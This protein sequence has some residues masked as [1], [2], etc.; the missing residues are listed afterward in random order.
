MIAMVFRIIFS[1]FLLLV[2][3]SAALSAESPKAVFPGT[4]FAFGKV[5]KGAAIEHEF[6]LRNEGGAPLR[7][8]GIR[9]TAPLQLG[10][11]PAQIEPNTEIK[12]R[13][14]LDTSILSGPFEDRS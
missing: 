13:V 9:A 11:M 7:I 10:R 5:M 12:L 14:Q 4:R 2:P 6:V 3:F 1:V 8:L